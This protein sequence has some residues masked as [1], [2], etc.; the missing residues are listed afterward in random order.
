VGQTFLSGVWARHSCLV[1][2]PDIPVWPRPT[3]EKR[4][5][6]RGSFAVPFDFAQDDRWEHLAALRFDLE[7]GEIVGARRSDVDDGDRQFAFGGAFGESI[8]RPDRER[9]SDDEQRIRFVDARH[10]V[11]D[12]VARHRLAEEYDRRL[13]H[14]TASRAGRNIEVVYDLAGNVG[15]AIGREVGIIGVKAM[16]WRIREPRL[17]HSRELV[18]KRSAR[19]FVV[20]VETNDNAIATVQLHDGT[21]SRFL[22][23][24][25]DVLRDQLMN[26]AALFE[27][28]ERAM[29]RIRPRRFEPRPS[30]KT[31]RPVEAP[32]LG[33]PHKRRIL[34]RFVPRPRAARTAIVRDSRLR[35]A[36]GAS[37]DDEAAR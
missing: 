8:S 18:L 26:A 34:N 36:T 9:R 37:E 16:P 6:G 4:W 30:A 21:A 20:T 24:I 25:V 22:M 1:C 3:S 35:A 27:R 23:Q 19:K 13:Q 5:A 14:A 12:F 15:I 33:A 29:R 31:A 28:S 10:R 7:R 2:G 11:V 32:H 17:I